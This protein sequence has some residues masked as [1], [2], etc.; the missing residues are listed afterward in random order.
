MMHHWSYLGVALTLLVVGSF[1]PHSLASDYNVNNQVQSRNT[2][3]K[4]GFDGYICEL[5]QGDKLN[6]TVTLVSGDSLNISVMSGDE[7]TNL[8]QGKSPTFFGLYSRYR[9][10]FYEDQIDAAG[11]YVGEIVLVVTTQGLKNSTSTYDVDVRINKAQGGQGPWEQLCGLG[12]GICAILIVG[13]IV[14]VVIIYYIFKRFSGIMKEER[15]SDERPSEA[16]SMGGMMRP[17]FN[18]AIGPSVEVKKTKART[19]RGKV[20]PR[21]KSEVKELMMQKRP[22]VKAKSLRPGGCPSCGEPVDASQGYCP[23]CGADL[24]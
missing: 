15:P 24:E 11:L 7:Y 18:V 2:V 16:K 6:W 3:E 13:A 1:V 21:S 10:D 20:K 12:P 19:K 14:V 17:G 23:S 9:T 4:K 22:P 5:N 8:K